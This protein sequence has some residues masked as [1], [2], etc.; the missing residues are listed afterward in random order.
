MHEHG[1][2]GQYCPI[3]KGA[4]IFAD[5]WTPLIIRE[6]HFEDIHHFNELERRLPG[7]SRSLLS[8]RL[9]RLERVGV[10]E[11]RPGP[12]GRVAY[13]LTPPGRELFEVTE[14]LGQWAARWAFTDP[15]PDE[16]DPILLMAWIRRSIHRDRL[17]PRR[18][19]VQFDFRGAQRRTIWLILEPSDVSVCLQNPGFDVDLLVSADIEGFYRYWL[20]R[21]E[22]YD[23]VED[24]LITVEG[25][26]T[27]L[28]RAF[29]TW[30]KRSHFAPTIRTAMTAADRRSDRAR[31]VAPVRR[32][33]TTG[34][35]S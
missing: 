13:Y 11:R 8:Q 22:F 3:A 18:T 6:L 31:A 29:P 26:P 14:V 32:T 4:E 24:G 20:G 17:P 23:A 21:I 9:R 30:L 1:S 19:T 2:Y 27:A 12:G 35:A 25:S 28:V 16:V 33:G 5:R 34:V 15:R 10:I 7:I